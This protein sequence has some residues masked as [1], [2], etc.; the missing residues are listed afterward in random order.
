[1]PMWGLS[2]SLRPCATLGARACV[3]L[4]IAGTV[5]PAHAIFS[6]DEARR[7]I[8]ELRNRVETQRIATEQAQ[9][10][11]ARELKELSEG[12]LATTRRSM[13]ELVGQMDTLRS[14]VADLRGQNERL[15]RDVAELQRQQR[16][17]LAALDE[18]LRNLEPVRVSLEG[19]EFNARPEEKAA[20]EAA[21]AA[22]RAGDF[23][24]AARQFTQFLERYPQSGYQNMV[25]YWQGNA[26]YA[27]RNYQAA[28][29]AYQRLLERA[30]QHAKAPEALLAIANSHLELKDTRA[31][32]TALQQVIARYPASEAATAARERLA[33]LR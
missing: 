7:A 30:P 20:Y 8:L 33:R 21:L 3:A 18:R 10:Q 1:M 11:T 14:E 9:Q 29:A 31:A 15:A 27:T 22:V 26:L 4:L 32:R 25:W 24:G 12:G 13:L 6:D 5:L 19:E 16:D 28:I 23:A 17:L 2:F